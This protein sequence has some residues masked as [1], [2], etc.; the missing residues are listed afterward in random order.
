MPAECEITSRFALALL[1]LAGSLSGRSRAPT[2]FSGSF[3][4]HPRA[5]AT[6]TEV[7]H[8]SGSQAVSV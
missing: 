7:A 3:A 6:G 5:E 1:D 2:S 4:S 8:G